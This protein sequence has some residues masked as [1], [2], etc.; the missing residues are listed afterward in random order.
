MFR[1]KSLVLATASP[2]V[3]GLPSL[4]FGQAGDARVSPAE[5]QIEEVVVTARKREELLN[6]IP[7]SVQMLGGSYLED[8]AVT[9]VA[10]MQW[11]TPG[12]SVPGGGRGSVAI[13]GI[14]NN[15]SGLGS[16]PSTAVHYDGV[17]LPR[18]GLVLREFYDL[19][20][21]EVM[22]GPEGT[23]Y[24]RNATA[25]VINYITRPPGEEFSAE[26]FIGTGAFG[27]VRSNLAVDVPMGRGGIRV[28]GAYSKD[29]GYTKII[30][31]QEFADELTW[32]IP[33]TEAG[34]PDI[35]NVDY[36][37]FRI[38]G[39]FEVTDNLT[40]SFSVQQISDDGL[41]GRAQSN[42]P[43]TDNL[44][45]ALAGPLQRRSPRRISVDP[46]VSRELDGLMASLVFEAEFNDIEFRSVTGYVDYEDELVSDTDGTGFYIERGF[47]LETSEFFS[48]EF[49]FSGDFGQ[50]ATWTGGVYFSKEDLGQTASLIDSFFE[51]G[52]TVFAA[53]RSSADSESMAI[54]AELT[55]DLTEKLTA[56]VGGRY[57]SE[58][59]NGSVIGENLDFGTFLPVPYDGN[60]DISDSA[61]TPKFALR[62]Q[63][64]P[65][66]MW[67]VSATNGFKS[68]GFNADNPV[69]SFGP[70]EIWAYELGTKNTLLDGRVTMSAAAFF[71][72]YEDIQLQTAFFPPGGGAFV[73]ITNAASAEIAGLEFELDAKL[74]PTLSLDLGV[75]HLD[76]S[77]DGYIPPGETQEVGIDM[78]LAPD[79]Q[80]VVG[81]D[82]TNHGLQ[83]RLEY[84][85]QSEIRFSPRAQDIEREDSIGLVNASIRYDFSESNWYLALIGRNLA[86]ET[87]LTNRFF[88][89]GF[90]DLETYAAPRQWEFRIGARF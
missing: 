79:W 5:L 53:W 47:G 2:V 23:L 8:M 9:N 25:G 20:R 67:Y 75:S 15:I 16:D 72:D 88:F 64:D 71:Y 76:T 13:R 86:D 33:F 90:S 34:S 55:Y 39:V 6:E 11:V 36:Q 17:Y 58:E 89:A 49:Q 70:E 56:T 19:E 59:K 27:L 77:V 32:E 45:T 62:Y 43:E 24:G 1:V 44:A 26:G 85:Y 50:S 28:S 7:A 82:Y 40:T 68:G 54:F 63:I 12:L 65:D 4:A 83:A 52:D 41:V 31:A 46:V 78:P 87:Y 69:T 22:K 10:D 14:S 60:V 66:H 84:T 18:P 35:D 73:R 29:D 74:T 3:L 48:Q 38:N 81:I 51:P 42:V 21:I 61:F 57:T 80:G 37:S 30:D